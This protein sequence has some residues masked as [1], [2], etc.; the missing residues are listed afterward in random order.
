MSL[1]TTDNAART[2]N[3][4]PVTKTAMPFDAESEAIVTFCC[5]QFDRVIKI[6]FSAVSPE[7]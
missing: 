2:R 5:V 4:I 7:V 1:N 3:T 6:E